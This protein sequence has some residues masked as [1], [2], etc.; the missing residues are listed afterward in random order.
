MDYAQTEYKTTTAQCFLLAFPT[1]T[2]RALQQSRLLY[3]D[4]QGVRP[5]VDL[6]KE[7]IK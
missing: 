7:N 1:G 6:I 4:R 3:G 2:I 5:L